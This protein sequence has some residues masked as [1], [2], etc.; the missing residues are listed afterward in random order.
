MRAAVVTVSWLLM[1]AISEKLAAGLEVFYIVCPHI[2]FGTVGRLAGLLRMMMT[3]SRQKM[4]YGALRSDM[5][6][7]RLYASHN[8]LPNELRPFRRVRT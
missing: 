7:G 2:V 3:V 6:E 8:G 1:P 4:A 5:V